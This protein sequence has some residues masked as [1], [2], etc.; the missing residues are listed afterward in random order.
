M[1]PAGPAPRACPEWE[2]VLVEDASGALAPEDARRLAEHAAGCPGCRAEAALLDEV[3]SL[4][5]LPPA[6]A[7]ERRTV[8]VGA[9]AALA[10]WKSRRRLARTAAAFAAAVSVAA[11]AVLVA[12]SPGLLRRT[13]TVP[14]TPWSPPDVEE[15][16]DVAGVALG[17]ADAA[18]EAAGGGA[19][20]VRD[21]APAGWAAEAAE[22][23]LA[24]PDAAADE[25]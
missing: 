19:V 12:A 20:E 8:A 14:G 6:P 25:D 3:L 21:A 22:D 23:L 18:R 24:E 10:R 17:A 7:D 4:A 1:S 13:P 9:G 11:A 16:W 5:A 2:P 15:V